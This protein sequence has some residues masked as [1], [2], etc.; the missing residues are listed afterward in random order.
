M[1][2]SMRCDGHLDTQCMSEFHQ[3]SSKLQ[4]FPGYGS[5][6]QTVPSFAKHSPGLF[7]RENGGDGGSRIPV[8]IKLFPPFFVILVIS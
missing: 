4:P 2:E 5:D 3:L 1:L 8:L 6:A 7:A